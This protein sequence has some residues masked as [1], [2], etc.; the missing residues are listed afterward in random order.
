MQN[1]VTGFTIAMN[2]NTSFTIE[3]R[4]RKMFKNEVK[5]MEIEA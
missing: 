2:E 3:K 5:W 4:G 1:I